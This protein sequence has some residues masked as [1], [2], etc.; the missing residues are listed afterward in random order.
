MTNGQKL[1]RARQ[2]A[3]T[4]PGLARLEVD[5]QSLTAKRVTIREGWP[6]PGEPLTGEWGAAVATKA[7]R[8]GR[9]DPVARY[10]QDERMI[11]PTVL[12]IL[13]D[14]INPPP[15]CV[16]PF[17]FKIKRRRRGNHFE[18]K[19]RRRGNSYNAQRQARL[20]FIGWHATMLRDGWAKGKLDAA[21]E[22]T[23]TDLGVCEADVYRGLA[24]F[25]LITN[26]NTVGC[27]TGRSAPPNAETS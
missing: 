18:I 14:M 16:E 22:Q 20:Q 5:E 27:I 6:E 24:V 10:F 15:G 26:S 4:P 21:V 7:L 17:H 8:A 2:L 13:A 1:P 23:K 12:L 9:L 11:S 25:R 19:R 3:N